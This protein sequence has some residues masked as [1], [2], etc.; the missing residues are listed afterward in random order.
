PSPLVPC[1]L[2]LVPC[3]LLLAPCSLFLLL[4]A[5]LA[6][7]AT[8]RAGSPAAAPSRLTVVERRVAQDQGGWVVH[9]R[10]RYHGPAGMVVTPTEV[11]AKVEG[12][13]SNSRVAAHAVP[14]WSSVVVSGAAGLSAAADV[15]GAADESQRCRERAAVQVWTDD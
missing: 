3:S 7:P 6:P 12:W 13:V 5:A 15:V 4:A 10:L 8:A 2:F 11:T 9:Y 1:P 14:R